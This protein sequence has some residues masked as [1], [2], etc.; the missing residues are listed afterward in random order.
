MS[1]IT[2]TTDFGIQDGFVGVMKGVILGICPQA[3]LID[4]T[5]QISPQNVRQ[6]AFVLARHTPY[7]PPGTVHIV[8]VDPGVGTARRPI[9]AQI[10][11]QYF[12]APD[13]GVLSAM[14]EY[15]ED[16]GLPL[17]MV[18]TNKP[19]YWL[20]KISNVFH[21]R[22]IF[23]PVGAHLASGI[24]LSELGELIIDPIRFEIPK[25]VKTA[26]GWQGEIIAIDHFGNAASNIHQSTVGDS[27]ITRVQVGA[28]ILDGIV[29]TFGEKPVGELIALFG[30]SGNLFVAEVN[31]SAA[32]RLNLAIG[33]PFSIETID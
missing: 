21:G 30:S 14:Y 22:D 16:H 6:A 11:E 25:P 9:A 31:G 7:F 1:I 4:I 18:H 8:V 29:K 26:T 15:A 20:Q 27:Q 5:Q 3:R 13:N 28:T 33:T 32:A 19:A 10:G 12:V 2:I 17:K 24:P 23:A